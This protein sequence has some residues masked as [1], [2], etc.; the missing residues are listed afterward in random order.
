MDDA[1]FLSY[2]HSELVKSLN[3]YFKAE[4]SQSVVFREAA[5]AF[6]ETF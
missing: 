6:T 4:V 3:V 5:S 1:I 2:K